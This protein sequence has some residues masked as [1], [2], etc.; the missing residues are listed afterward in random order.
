MDPSIASTRTTDRPREEP[1]RPRGPDSTLNWNGGNERWPEEVVAVGGRGGG[2]GG[3]LRRTARSRVRRPPPARPAV[4]RV[5]RPAGLH[6]SCPGRGWLAVC[7]RAERTGARGRSRKGRCAALPR[8]PPPRPLWRGAGAPVH[9]LRPALPVE[10]HLLR[11]LYGL[12]RQPR[13]GR[14]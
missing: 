6:R 4:G 14:V 3:A 13:G 9:R 5:V 11:R 2:R 10:S 7:G 8:H 12:G 1:E